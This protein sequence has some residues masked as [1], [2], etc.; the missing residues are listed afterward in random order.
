M[1]KI[2]LEPA[3]NGVIK[4]IEDDNINGAGETATYSLVYELDKDES[5]SR[6]IDFLYEIVED[7]G[8]NK[9]NEF[10]D[11]V[12]TIGVNWGT[13]YTPTPKDIKEKIE[14]LEYELSVLR[15]ME[16]NHDRI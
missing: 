14:V 12:I 16:K 8:I 7:L 1:I 5:F 11:K 10:T 3:D 9:G 4:R 15:E 6:A 13:E 2:I